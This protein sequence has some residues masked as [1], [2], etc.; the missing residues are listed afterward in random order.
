MGLVQQC[1]QTGVFLR[2]RQAKSFWKLR[3]DLRGN[4]RGGFQ[5]LGV[6]SHCAQRSRKI[7]DRCRREMVLISFSSA[8]RD[9]AVFE[10]PDRVMLDRKV[11]PHL[12]FGIGIHRCIGAD[13]ARMQLRVAL[14]VFLNATKT[15]ELAGPVTWSPG[16]VRGPASL[17][18]RLALTKP[19]APRRVPLRC[20]GPQVIHINGSISPVRPVELLPSVV[21]LM[22]QTQHDNKWNPHTFS[23]LL[24][25]PH[26]L[27]QLALVVDD[28]KP[29]AFVTWG[30][31]DLDAIDAVAHGTRK[32]QAADWNA[33]EDLWVMDFCCP[34]GGTAKTS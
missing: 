26:N 8:N 34:F 3:I 16:A 22:A 11:N 12:A 25:P 9:A 18:L 10:L 1:S 21:W 32:L 23:R 33:G 24:L 17:P 15:C 4:C 27:R 13:L 2:V 7:K 19:S 6:V 31:F 28:A 20:N 14:E 5:H 30:L 29:L